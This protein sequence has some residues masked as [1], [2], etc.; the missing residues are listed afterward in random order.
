MALISLCMIVKDEEATLERCLESARAV[1]DEVVIVD[2]G[3]KDRT[4]EIAARYT[5]RVFDLPWTG[6][7]SAARNFSVSKAT[8]K[9]IFF[10]DADETVAAADA[11]AIR[12]LAVNRHFGGFSFLVRSYTDDAML[13]NFVRLENDP[14]PESSGFQGYDRSRVVRMFRRDEGIR[15]E[16]QIHELVEP[17]ILRSGGRVLEVDIPIHHFG[18]RDEQKNE[19]YLELS[20]RRAA[21]EGSAKARFSLAFSMFRKAD[22]DGAIAE[23][24]K[25]LELEPMYREAWF[26]LSEALVKKGD[27]DGAIRANEEIARR[28]PRDPGGH[29]NLGELC[30]AKGM[31]AKALE[32]YGKALEMGSPQRERIMGILKKLEGR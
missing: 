6:D 11:E 26:G 3:S 1:A 16:G 27:L 13:A 28:W 8:G 14:Y 21:T 30:L 12:R 31:K 17:S 24:G 25:A 4:K 19:H 5:D 22:M 10:L 18:Q 7:F 32:H 2:T 15:F 9:W 29:Y 23:Y 20:R